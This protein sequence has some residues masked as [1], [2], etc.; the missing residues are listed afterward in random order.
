MITIAYVEFRRLNGVSRCKLI[1]TSHLFQIML[2][3]FSSESKVKISN[4]SI[5]YCV[6]LI[7][8]GCMGY[9]SLEG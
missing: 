6:P 2:T 7:Y 5:L 9:H 8:L 4:I 1:F 3:E